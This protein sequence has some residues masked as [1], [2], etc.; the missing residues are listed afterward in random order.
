MK[1]AQAPQLDFFA[2]APNGVSPP[3][4]SE[5]GPAEVPD[6]VRALGERL[7]PLIRLGTSSWHFPGW[8]GLVYNRKVST[9]ELTRG[10][11][12]HYAKHPLLRTVGLDR[13]YYSPMPAEGYRAY[14]DS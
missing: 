8:A 5:L 13:T 11:L 9:T 3:A 14:A 2:T 6:S 4:P 12:T 10:G 7:P 1:K